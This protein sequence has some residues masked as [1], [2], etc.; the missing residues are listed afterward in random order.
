MFILTSNISIT[1][2]IA[3]GLGRHTYY[4]TPDQI[5]YQL[6]IGE[7]VAEPW[8]IMA[9]ALGKVSVSLLILRI[10]GPATFWRKWI[11]YVS[12]PLV[13]AVNA[14]ATILLFAQCSPVHALWDGVENVPG[15]QCWKPNIQADF[16]AFGG[17]KNLSES[18][19]RVKTD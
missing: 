12:I 1:F 11:I 9:I 10:I 7:Y 3:H 18:V 8:S 13:L 15:A 5:R 19:M 17:C 4:L 16:S 14:T 6:L 2:A